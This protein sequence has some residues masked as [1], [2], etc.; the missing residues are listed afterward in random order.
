MKSAP[1]R[2]RGG[3]TRNVAVA[4]VAW[5]GL[6]GLL[7]LVGWLVS[8]GRVDAFDRRVT[9]VIVAH[10]TAALDTMMRAVTWLGSWAAALVTGVILVVL[11]LR[12]RITY[13]F[14]LLVV[15]AWAGE[16]AGVTLTKRIVTRPRPPQAIRLVT[17]H[18]WSWPS[19]H[20]ATAVIVFG[21]LVLL[22]TVTTPRI[23][24]R[25]AAWG[26]AVIALG[27]VGFSRVELGVHW[28]TDVI[29]GA[30][31]ASCWLATLLLVTRHMRGPCPRAEQLN[32]IRL[33]LVSRPL[34]IASSLTCHPSDPRI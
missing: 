29:A 22:V 6:V 33:G 23:A 21:T 7:V 17:A 20:T 10:R 3:L 25:A 34:E 14:F 16:A 11:V 9:A 1:R 32:P 27:L 4:V 8:R 24:V 30:I 31:F 19:G 26:V 12:R 15:A 2:V 5:A 13:L 28:A 18:G